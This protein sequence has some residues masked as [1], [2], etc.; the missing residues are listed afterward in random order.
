MHTPQARS[1]RPTAPRAK[2]AS[3]WISGPS[4]NVS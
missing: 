1:N 2:S 4:S 3:E